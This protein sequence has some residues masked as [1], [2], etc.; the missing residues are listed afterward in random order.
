MNAQ[1]RSQIIASEW[2]IDSQ[3]PVHSISR[4]KRRA[5]YSDVTLWWLVVQLNLSEHNS[6]HSDPR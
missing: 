4:L 6:I 3:N 5:T 2:M 1:Q